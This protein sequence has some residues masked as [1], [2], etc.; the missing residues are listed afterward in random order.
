MSDLDSVFKRLFGDDE[1]ERLGSGWWSGV[2][3]VFFRPHWPLSYGLEGHPVPEGY[4]EQTLW[5]WRGP[6][7]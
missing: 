5:P 7:R 2:A 6:A 4:V 3:A 1:P